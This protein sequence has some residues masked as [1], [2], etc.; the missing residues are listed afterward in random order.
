MALPLCQQ[1]SPLCLGL[2]IRVGMIWGEQHE[3]E[4]GVW[5]EALRAPQLCPSPVGLTFP[6]HLL[7][8]SEGSQARA[9]REGIR[10]SEIKCISLGNASHSADQIKRIKVQGG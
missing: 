10:N 9:K 2:G 1:N 6:F 5:G 7:G 3:L 8:S 4:R